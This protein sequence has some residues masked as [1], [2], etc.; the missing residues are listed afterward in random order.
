MKIV[1]IHAI[2]T[3]VKQLAET[4]LRHVVKIVRGPSCVEFFALSNE[5]HIWPYYSTWVGISEKVEKTQKGRNSAFSGIFAV[6][7]PDSESAAEN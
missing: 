1:K 5:V 6:F 3:K 4:S 7:V 2:H